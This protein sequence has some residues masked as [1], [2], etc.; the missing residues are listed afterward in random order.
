M[1]NVI[2]LLSV[3]GATSIVCHGKIFQPLREYLRERNFFFPLHCPQCVGFWMAIIL[4]LAMWISA[5]GIPRTPL[6]NFVLLFIF[7]C[8]GSL[9]SYMACMFI[10]DYG[11][12][13]SKRTK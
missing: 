9:V 10:D 6:R 2:Y 1:E 4:R 13:I 12:R 8:A 3:A 7:G 5:G 11:V